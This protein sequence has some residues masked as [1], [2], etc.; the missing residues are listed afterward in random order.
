MRYRLSIGYLAFSSINYLML[1]LMMAAMLYPFLYVLAISLSSPQMV[2]AGMVKL[3]PKGF[4]FE[5]YRYVIQDSLLLRAYL[6]TIYYAAMATVI[7]LATTIMTSYPLAVKGFSG[8]KFYVLYF[9]V[10]MF[11]SGGL[12]P[13]YIV[14]TKLH[15]INT[16]WAM[17]LPGISVWFILICRTFFQDIPD[18]L[19]ESA[20]IDGAN[21]IQILFKIYAPLSKA[22]MATIALYTIVGQWNN[23]FS[24]LIFLNDRTKYPL[25]MVIRRMLVQMEYSARLGRII[26]ENNMVT[27][28]NLRCATIIVTI[29]PI[30]C[31]YPFLQKYFI[32]GVMIGSI[33]G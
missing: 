33:K 19:R 29:L 30:V 7:T 9:A 15:L 21:D 27:G 32:K 4:T 18:S 25:Q 16:V 11:F 13:Y 31:M 23:F 24:A 6:N 5:S 14:V 26:S 3:I 1:I 22:I 17:V 8:K 2:M 12:I 28:Q 10:T 20:L